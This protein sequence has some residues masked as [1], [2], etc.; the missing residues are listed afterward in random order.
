MISMIIPPPGDGASSSCGISL[1]D[2]SPEQRVGKVH[3]VSGPQVV[4]APSPTP[5][6]FTGIFNFP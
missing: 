2:S 5:M 3:R 6:Y 1:E 4:D